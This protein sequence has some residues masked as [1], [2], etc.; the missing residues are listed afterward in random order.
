MNTIQFDWVKN[1]MPHNTQP[2]PP[3]FEPEVPAAVV[4]AAGYARWPR[5]E[6]WVGTSTTMAIVGQMFIPGLL[7]RYLGK[8]GYKSQQLQ[9]EPRDP[10]APNNLYEYVPGVHSTRGKFDARSKKSSVEVT[11]AMHR[12][13]LAV[14]AL[15]LIA[16]AAVVRMEPVLKRDGVAIAACGVAMATLVPVLLHQVGVVEHLPDPPG[17]WFGSDEITESE[18]AHP[19]GV[20][21]ALLGL[22][23]Y[24]VTMGL[25]VAARRHKVVRPLLAAKLAGDAGMAGFNVVRQVV[26]FG[27]VCSWCTGTAVATAVM[28]ACGRRQRNGRP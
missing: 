23:S 5:R 19:L 10:D 13:V 22:V 9:D 14:G 3:I 27:K 26:Q 2:V 17:R 21:D 12:N 18:A 20:P 4:V 7:D 8:T 15:G 11:L 24:G 16:A 6:Y 25:L 1:R 28:V